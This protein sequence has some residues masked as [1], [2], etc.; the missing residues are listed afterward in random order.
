VQ[1]DPGSLPF[2]YDLYTFRGDAGKTSIVAAFAVPA[3]KL[4][5]QSSG[6]QVSYRFDVTLVLA[7]TALKSVSRTDDTVFVA[8]RR[9]LDDK[10]LLHTYI[11]VQAPPSTT[12]LERVIM[13]DATRPGIG[14]M[15]GAPFP[16]PDYRGKQ[17]MLSD[18][19]LGLPDS[20]AGWKRGDVTLEL[21]PTSQFPKSAFDVYYEI[22]NLPAGHPYETEVSVE[23]VAD[24]KG[25]ESKNSNVVRARFT[26]RATPLPDGS[27]HELRHLG[28]SLDKGRYRLSVTVTD[29]ESGQTAHRSRVFDVRGWGSGATLVPALPW[30][31]KTDSAG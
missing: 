19:V 3:G 27:V 20:S 17:L 31:T 11:E 14:Q 22:Y 9:S 10:H 15:Y 18:V 4:R 29:Q 24:E 8:A 5:K 21:L 16:I 7:D 23:R 12:T 25:K 6:N 30:R 13:N 1:T 26:G 2:F 28:S